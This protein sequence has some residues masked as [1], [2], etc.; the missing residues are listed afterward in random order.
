[1]IKGIV[2]DVDGTLLNSMPVWE[3]LGELYLKSLGIAAEKDLRNILFEMSLEEGAAYLIKTYGLALTETEVVSG[4]NRRVEEFYREKVPLKEGVRQ[5]LDEFKAVS[6]THLDVY[7]RQTP[8]REIFQRFGWY[9]CTYEKACRDHP[10][11][12]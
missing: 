3:N 6:Y 5:Y 11:E 8:T 4:L 2:F 7:K 9:P 10:S 12:I 1:M